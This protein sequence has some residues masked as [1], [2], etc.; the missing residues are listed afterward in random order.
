MSSLRLV[1]A[2]AILLLAAA[3]PAAAQPSIPASEWPTRPNSASSG[4]FAVAQAATD[5]ADQFMRDWN[6]ATPGA[7]LHVT[8][9]IARGRPITTFITF[10]GC[11]ADA[12][13]NCNVTATFEL[14]DPS[15]KT[16]AV[17][18]I[19]V[20]A[21]HPGP[22]AGV[23]ALSNASLG[24]TFDDSDALGVHTISATITDDVAGVTLHTREDITVTK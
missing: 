14:R 4:L 2:A 7:Q 12:A 15:G 8:H 24:L 16:T 10:R 1:P 20:W 5:D 22:P 9:Q 13:G 23:I 3:A 11:R 6:K 21:H 18:A 17:P 19:E